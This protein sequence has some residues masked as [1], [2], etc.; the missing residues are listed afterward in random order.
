MLIARSSQR[1]RASSGSVAGVSHVIPTRAQCIK[2]Y[3]RPL[4][5][6]HL[7]IL[8][9]QQL[10]MLLL[11]PLVPLLRAL[12]ASVRCCQLHAKK[13]SIVPPTCRQCENRSG[14]RG[15]FRGG[16]RSGFQRWISEWISEWNSGSIW[17]VNFEVDFK[18]KSAADFLAPLTHLSALENPL[19]IHFEIHFG[20]R[21]DNLG[22]GAA[23]RGMPFDW[24]GLNCW[25]DWTDRLT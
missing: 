14:F 19:E 25:T 15:G 22:S 7:L 10:L 24:T 1:S 13:H 17:A 3:I 6:L 21:A 23:L 11:L 16:F 18:W 8:F 12:T 2:T 5:L 4:P 9:V 20:F